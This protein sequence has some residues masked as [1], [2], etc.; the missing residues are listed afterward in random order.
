MKGLKKRICA[1]VMAGTMM[2]GGACSVYAATFGDKNSGASSDEYVEFVYHGTAWN[3]KKSSYKSTYFVY[4]RNGRTLMK[5]TA[6]N[7]KVSGN[8]TDDI[9]WGDKYTTKFKWGHGAKK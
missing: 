7:G 4:T 6:Y 1:L 5:K 9:R 2:F 3:Y 8:V